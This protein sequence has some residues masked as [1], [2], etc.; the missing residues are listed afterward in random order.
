MA[1]RMKCP[2][3][4]CSLSL[5]D[6]LR[7]K[8]VR[9]KK[10]EAAVRVPEADDDEAPAEEHA[11]QETTKLKVRKKAAPAPADEEDE[12][13]RPVKKKK[14]KKARAGAPLVL[15]ALGAIAVILL[16]AGGGTAAYFFFM[17]EPAAP[18]VQGQAKAEERDERSGAR[19]VVPGRKEGNPAK[20]GGLGVVSNVRGAAFRAERRNELA[21]INK[22][23]AMWALEPGPKTLD[24]Y[25]AFIQRDFKPGYDAIKEGYYKVNVKAKAGTS[26]IV[27]GERDED[28]GG[29]LVVRSNAAVEHVPVAEFKKAFP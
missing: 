9:C 3:C 28:V 17:R 19:I 2:G 12:E 21:N 1:I 14:K 15:I 13:E 23:H 7:G 18:I 8:K 4:R 10:C 22:M 6:H 5:A 11:V 16:L 29:H 20:K 24:G 26:E 25:L 27:A